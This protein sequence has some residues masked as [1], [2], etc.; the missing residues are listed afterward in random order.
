M[1]RSSLKLLDAVEEVLN[2]SRI[3]HLLLMVSFSHPTH[4][5]VVE[6]LIGPS[7]GTWGS[8]SVLMEVC[9]IRWGGWFVRGWCLR[10]T[11]ALGEAVL[12]GLC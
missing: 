6:G 4:F 12:F 8:L 5:R 9:C 10:V 11:P 3:V 1:F 7:R 2:D